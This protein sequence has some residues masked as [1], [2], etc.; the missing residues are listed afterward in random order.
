MK[1]DASFLSTHQNCTYVHRG[2]RRIVYQTSISRASYFWVVTEFREKQA[3][4]I[5]SPSEF[6]LSSS[7]DTYITNHILYVAGSILW[8][9]FFLKGPISPAEGTG[10][11]LLPRLPIK[12]FC[13]FIFC[14]ESFQYNHKLFKYVICILSFSAFWSYDEAAQRSTGSAALLI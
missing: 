5:L 2:I 14:T 1:I 10:N 12:S 13:S 9:K 11:N 8:C 3:H 7:C 4:G 6:A